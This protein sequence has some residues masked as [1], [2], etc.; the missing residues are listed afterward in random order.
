MWWELTDQLLSLFLQ[1][2]DNLLL[3][4]E[5]AS[6]NGTLQSCLKKSG[7]KDVQLKQLNG[8]ISG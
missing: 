7:A 5:I 4:V 3:H 6:L 2:I 8:Q 1:L